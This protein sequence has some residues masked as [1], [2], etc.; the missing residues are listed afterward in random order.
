MTNQNIILTKEDFL[1]QQFTENELNQSIYYAGIG[2]RDTPIEIQIF[3]KDLASKLEQKGF[4]LR[5]GGAQ[6]ADKAFENGVKFSK[7]KQIFYQSHANDLVR[8][9]A[10]VFHPAP[11]ALNKSQIAWNLMARNTFQIMGKDLNQPVR[12]VILWTKDGCKHHSSRTRNTGGTGQAISIASHFS[13][14][15]FNLYHNKDKEEILKLIQ[16]F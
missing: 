6:G 15:V 14:P 8:E 9:I 4:I 11:Y 16:S 10:N 2:S 3:M 1:S 12:F 13:I 7:N 5:S